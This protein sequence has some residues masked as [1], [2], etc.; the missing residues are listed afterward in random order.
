MQ[1][2]SQFVSPIVIHGTDSLIRLEGECGKYMTLYLHAV[3]RPGTGFEKAADC[4]KARACAPVQ[5]DRGLKTEAG[6]AK[7]PLFKAEGLPYPLYC[8]KIQY[9]Y[10]SIIE[11]HVR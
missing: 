10:C 5:C 3:K 7:M 1:A 9:S 8:T 4:R 6:A 11:R 2:F